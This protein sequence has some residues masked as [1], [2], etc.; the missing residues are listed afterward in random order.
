MGFDEMG[1]LLIVYFQFVRYLRKKK[2]IQWGNAQNSKKPVIQLG[3]RSCII[4]LL[5]LVSPWYC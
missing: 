2:G 3:G 1:Q 4:F 5:S